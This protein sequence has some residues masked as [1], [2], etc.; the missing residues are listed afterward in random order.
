MY[1]TSPNLSWNLRTKFS[2]TA[3]YFCRIRGVKSCYFNHW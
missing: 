2:G 1:I 3:K